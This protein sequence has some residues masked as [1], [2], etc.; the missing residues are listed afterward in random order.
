M[1]WCDVYRNAEIAGLLGYGLSTISAVTLMAIA[2]DRCLA[3]TTKHKYKSIVTKKRSLFVVIFLWIVPG[4]LMV[5]IFHFRSINENDTIIIT[6]LGLLF[7]LTIFILYSTCLYYLKKLSSQVAN[8]P[9]QPSSN[10]Q[11]SEFNIWKYKRS[12]VTMVMVL[13]LILMTF[14]PL[15]IFFS[16]RNLSEVFNNPAPTLVCQSIV[17]L[18]STLNPILYLWRMKDLRQALRNIIRV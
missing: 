3:I 4:T 9:N 14:L 17:L 7:V 18:N 1:R 6:I 5:T 11:T 12:L 8:T 2:F 10:Q 16:T 13:G 15:V